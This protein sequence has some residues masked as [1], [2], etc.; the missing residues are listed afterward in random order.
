[1]KDLFDVAASIN[2]RN[3]GIQA[4]IDHADY[5]KPHWKERAL[6]FLKKYPHNEFMAE[7]LRAWAYLNGLPE[8]PHERAWG[9]VITAARKMGLIRHCGYS[10]VKNPNAHRTPASVWSKN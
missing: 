2:N 9:G 4:A 7:D 3:A 5:E 6:N 1:M 10:S 8:P